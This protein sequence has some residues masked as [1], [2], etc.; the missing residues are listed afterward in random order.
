MLKFIS[1]LDKKNIDIY[2]ISDKVG[3]VTTPRSLHFVDL[4]FIFLKISTSHHANFQHV[5]MKVHEAFEN[6]CTFPAIF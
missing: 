3:V 5:L 6:V 2:I 4:N 1:A